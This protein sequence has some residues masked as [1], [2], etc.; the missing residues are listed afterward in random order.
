LEKDGYIFLQYPH[1]LRFKD[2][3]FSDRNYINYSPNFIKK[4]CEKYFNIISHK[5]FFDGRVIGNFDTDSYS[6]LSKD[7]R[8]GYLLIAQRK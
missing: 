2:L 1:A 3:L 8:N 5:Q 7:F 4:N 6:T